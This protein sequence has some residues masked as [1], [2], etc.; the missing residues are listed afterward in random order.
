MRRAQIYNANSNVYTAF[1][2][3]ID[4]YNGRF[5]IFDI[6]SNKWIAYGNIRNN[7]IDIFD[8]SSNLFIKYGN[9]TGQR[10]NLYDS[11]TNEYIEY[12]MFS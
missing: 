12:G 1:L 10:F 9:L 11:R 4:E 7:R 8:A 6:N 3:V 2:N 5:D